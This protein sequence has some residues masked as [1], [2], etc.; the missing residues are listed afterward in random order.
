MI[1]KVYRYR[2]TFDEKFSAIP[3]GYWEYCS[4]ET[5]LEIKEGVDRGNQYQ[6]QVLCITHNHMPRE[7]E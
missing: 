6:L 1:E 3:Y 2:C 4:Y 5:Y 7:G